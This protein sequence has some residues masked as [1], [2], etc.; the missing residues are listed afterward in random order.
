MGTV[1]G[2]NTRR[3]HGLLVASLR[4]PVERYVLLSR[5]EE[6]ILCDGERHI[7]GAAQYPGVIAPSGFQLLEEFR[8]DP[9]PTWRYRTGCADV[10]KRLF[11][12]QGEQTVV[13]QYRVSNKARLC[14][15]PF[16]AYRD[17]HSLQH[18]N[19]GFHRQVEDRGAMLLARP[20]EGLPALRLFHNGAGFVPEGNWY[21]RNEYRKEMQRGLD[22]QEDVYSPGWIHFELSPGKTAYV[23]ATIEGRDSVGLDTLRGWEASERARRAASAAQARTEFE[24]RLNLAA[25]QFLVHRANGSPTIIA[26]Y[27]WFTDWGRDTMISLPGLL[28][29]RG[30]AGEAEHILKGFLDAMDQG[31]IPNRFPDAGEKP[32]Y[33]TADGT[34]WMFPAAW[35]LKQAGSSG[36]FLR[37]TFY[38][39]AKDILRW[40]RRGTHFGIGVDAGDGLLRAG[41]AGTQLTWMDAKAGDWV[42]TP[43]H[44]KPVEINALWYNALRMMA[45]WAH[46]YGELRYEAQLEA[47]AARVRTSFEEKFWNPKRRCLYD[48][49]APEG[50]DER[51]RPNQIFAVSLPFP[52]MNQDQRQSILER[53]EETLLTP[54]GLRTL[55]PDEPDYHGRYEGGPRERDGAYHQ[56][57]VWPWLLGPYLEARLRVLGLTADN[58]SFCNKLLQN[59]EVELQSYCLGSLAE[60]YDGD[61]PHR[62][63]GA[64]AQA[65]SVAELLR[66]IPLCLPDADINFSLGTSS[67]G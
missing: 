43:R 49:L 65:W 37:E 15:Q 61:A 2:A 60:I 45:C 66:L 16:L 59:M 13:V 18:A 24:A 3:Y 50:P 5:V 12:V 47:E 63:K 67:Q 40:H 57:T 25:D 52:L 29:T 7:L 19:E 20:Y 51:F 22:F 6:Q 58:L 39:A 1:A 4:P 33:N 23:V 31:L 62:P 56:G 11:L 8:R 42:V 41:A 32:E 44:G 34:L 17:Y 36:A 54:F 35:A 26:G 14:V 28:I 64:V 27:P 21:Y 48:R 30:R 38:P 55:A 9:F 46:E 10:E 53:V